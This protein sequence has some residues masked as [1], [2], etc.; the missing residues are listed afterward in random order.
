MSIQNRVLKIVTHNLVETKMSY[1]SLGTIQYK[2]YQEIIRYCVCLQR[3]V[4]KTMMDIPAYFKCPLWLPVLSQTGTLG[5]RTGMKENR[6]LPR[7][8]KT[9]CS[10]EQLE[11]KTF[12]VEVT[13]LIQCSKNAYGG[14]GDWRVFSEGKVFYLRLFRVAS[15]LTA[16]RGFCS[17][18]W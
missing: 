11:E 14:R 8:L 9:L 6:E 12:L 7:L 17:P 3:V 10:W 16:S 15:Q 1:T 2:L 13:I 18:S 5:F 4:S